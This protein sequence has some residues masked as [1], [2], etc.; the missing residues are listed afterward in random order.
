ML[1]KL[2]FES[3]LCIKPEKVDC[4]NHY[5]S[6]WSMLDRGM[7]NRGEKATTN[8]DS[9]NIGALIIVRTGTIA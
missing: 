6:M 3:I 5:C 9:Q 8:A 4:E 7:P 1:I 2:K